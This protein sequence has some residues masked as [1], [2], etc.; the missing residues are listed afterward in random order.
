MN[1]LIIIAGCLVLTLIL[2]LTLVWPEYQ[3]FQ[4]LQVN[5]EEK[6]IE[7]QSKEEY[8]SQIAEVS[9][10]LEQ[11]ESELAKIASA[12]PL[13]T[14][15]SSLFNFL[16]STAAQTGLVLEEITLSAITSPQKKK[17]SLKEIH[18]NLSMLGSYSALKDFLLTIEAS[19]RIIEVESISFESP[20][21]LTEP[22]TFIVEIKTY[23]Y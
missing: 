8:F 18:V 6:N 15:L 13:E 20:E 12:L 4:T 16:Q 10:Q 7:L 11:Y 3:S 17:D 21:D 23:S 22:F 14:S 1:K 19:S 5:I 2:G 9:L